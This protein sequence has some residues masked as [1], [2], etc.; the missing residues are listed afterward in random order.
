[1]I[2]IVCLTHNRVD[3]LARCVENVIMRTSEL[4]TEIVIWDNASP[5]GTRDY[6]SSL[7]DPRLDIV[8]HDE[9]IAMNALPRA[10]ERT[11]APYM[12]ELDD[13]VVEAPERWDA[14]LLE[15]YRRMPSIG[16][17]C[18]GIAYDA[19]D[20]ASRYLRYMREEIGAYRE[21]KINGVRIL[22]GSVGG[23]CTMTS[24]DL[25]RQVG[26]F[27]EHRRYPYWRPDIPYQRA[28]RKLGYDSAF[29]A[30]LEVRH[31]GGTNASNPPQPKLAYHIHER[32][33]TARKNTVKR[34]LLALP[35]FAKLNRRLGWFEPPIAPYDPTA[36]DPDE[37]ARSAPT[38]AG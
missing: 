30:D 12:V 5:D 1:M 4:T 11:T 25:Y 14:A 21:E 28:L 33:L 6:L 13:D 16:F 31:E 7:D 18:A 20:A 29:L 10:L 2:A 38:S 36:Y 17:L 24:R 23:A 35:G 27:K 15:A 32:K 22:R 3:L 19:N 9:N 26:G 8:F 34:V 37:G